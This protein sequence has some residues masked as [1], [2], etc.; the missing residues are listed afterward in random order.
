MIPA[1]RG[2]SVQTRKEAPEAP[3]QGRRGCQKCRAQR[4]H[5]VLVTITATTPEGLYE[6]LG[7]PG[8]LL[9][10]PKRHAQV[11]PLWTRRRGAGT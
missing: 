9:K 2:Y 7:L 10:E 8:T 4:Q 1:T 5:E 3:R 6:R 11:C